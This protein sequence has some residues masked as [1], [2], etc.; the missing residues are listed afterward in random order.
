MTCSSLEIDAPT[1]MCTL[2]AT[3][4]TLCC[5]LLLCSTVN[6]QQPIINCDVRLLQY[7]MM[8]GHGTIAAYLAFVC[9]V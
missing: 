7:S 4:A 2:Y 6:I 9:S 5:N 1:Y 3:V 8:Y